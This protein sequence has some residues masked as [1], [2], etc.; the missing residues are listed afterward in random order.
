MF[1]L[2]NPEKDLC[3]QNQFGL[4][5]LF[6]L[7]QVWCSWYAPPGKHDPYQRCL[8]RVAPN[9]DQPLQKWVFIIARSI[10]CS[11]LYSVVLYCTLLYYIVL[12]CTILYS[13]VLY[14][15]R[16]Y[17]IVLCCII[18][19][20]VVLCCTLGTLN[21]CLKITDSL[22]KGISSIRPLRAEKNVSFMF[23]CKT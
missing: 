15:T 2:Q 10:C 4:C 20:S 8:S 18:L 19:Y 21:L 14:C 5:K 1:P 11:I 3:N 12:C 16:L 9:I 22:E 23:K 7:N 17:Y 6:V 13:V